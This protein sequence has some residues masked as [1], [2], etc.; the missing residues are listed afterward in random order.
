MNVREQQAVA[1]LHHPGWLAIGTPDVSARIAERGADY[2]V[3]GTG[4]PV[5]EWDWQRR[6]PV[7]ATDGTTVVFENE[8][9]GYIAALATG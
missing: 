6:V 8:P 2:D 9:N 5:D 1:A 7:R 3:A 4:G